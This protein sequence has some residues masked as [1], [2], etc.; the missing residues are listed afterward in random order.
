M[1][2][3]FDT[4]VR[5]AGS[6]PRV[7]RS[8]ATARDVRG[9][10]ALLGFDDEP[11]PRLIVDPPLAEPLAAGKVFIQYRTENMRVLPVFGTGA[12]DVS[13]RVGH[14]HITVDDATW[15]FIDASGETVVVVGLAPGPH[16]IL[17]ELADPTHRV[18]DSQTVRFTVPG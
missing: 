4:E 16:R 11:P 14:V 18:I 3:S 1:D 13:P 2:D 8:A 6:V 7:T 12:L 17:F 15:H 10:S 5:A 9:P